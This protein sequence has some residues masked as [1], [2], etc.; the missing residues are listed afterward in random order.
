MNV[1]IGYKW[2]P[3]SEISGNAH[4]CIENIILRHQHVDF[5]H[6][7]P[8][9]SET[10]DSLGQS[11]SLVHVL[12]QLC[13]V[14]LIYLF[15]SCFWPSK[16]HGPSSSL[17]AVTWKTNFKHLSWQWHQIRL[18]KQG[19]HTYHHFLKKSKN[20]FLWSDPG[21]Q[22]LKL[23]RRVPIIGG[24]LGHVGKVCPLLLTARDSNTCKPVQLGGKGREKRH[25]AKVKGSFWVH[26]LIMLPCLEHNNEIQGV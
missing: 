22:V 5:Y 9:N 19:F 13:S 10:L 3:G 26:T 14:R 6:Y 15:C 23:R 20:L 4:L 17:Q 16:K 12:A 11:T 2:N 7:T 8:S 24:L 21:R 18:V 25:H 1:V